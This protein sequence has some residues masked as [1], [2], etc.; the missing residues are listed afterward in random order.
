MS[1][2]YITPT[3]FVKLGTFIK[4]VLAN[5]E[6]YVLF[7]LFVKLLDLYRRHLIPI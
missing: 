5:G 7:L 6:K 3:K 1:P 4:S 2:E